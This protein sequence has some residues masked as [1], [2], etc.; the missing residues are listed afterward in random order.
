MG[1]DAAIDYR[2]ASG[3][4][5]TWRPVARSYHGRGVDVS[6]VSSRRLLAARAG[7]APNRSTCQIALGQAFI[8]DLRNTV[9][10]PRPDVVR[11]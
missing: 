3:S 5:S 8:D 4:A 1:R 2:H 11:Q 7:I 10:A 9:N 6:D